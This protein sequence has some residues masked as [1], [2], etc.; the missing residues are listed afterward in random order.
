MCCFHY[1]TQG[2]WKQ[3]IKKNVKLYG[4]KQTS[5]LAI[6]QRQCFLHLTGQ[7]QAAEGS[8]S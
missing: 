1:Q 5:R 8:G 3:M 7:H 4:I 6:K 2:T